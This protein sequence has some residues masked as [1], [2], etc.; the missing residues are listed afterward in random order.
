[1][2]ILFQVEKLKD[3]VID[4]K[5]LFPSENTAH[6]QIRTETIVNTLTDLVNKLNNDEDRKIYFPFLY[7][8][9]FEFSDVFHSETF[10][11]LVKMKNQVPDKILRVGE[12]Y[13]FYDMVDLLNEEN[14]EENV[15]YKIF[16]VR[17]EL[18]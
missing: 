11:I 3:E 10:E 9:S 16:N 5:A 6:H 17:G 4:V 1:M 12:R 8:G 18:K 15:S 2:Y 7:A 14:T 13:S